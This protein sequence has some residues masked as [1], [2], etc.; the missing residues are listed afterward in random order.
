MTPVSSF[1]NIKPHIL[2]LYTVGLAEM[3]F[4]IKNAFNVLLIKRIF[5]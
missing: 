4:L 2:R 1:Y 3:G 5:F